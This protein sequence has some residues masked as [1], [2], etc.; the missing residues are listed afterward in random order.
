L[1]QSAGREK[2]AETIGLVVGQLGRHWDLITQRAFEKSKL[3][4]CPID[5]MDSLSPS[6]PTPAVQGPEPSIVSMGLI[7]D[8]N[9]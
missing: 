1:Q 5:A 7:V 8:R 2:L 6:E 9:F 4:P 3:R